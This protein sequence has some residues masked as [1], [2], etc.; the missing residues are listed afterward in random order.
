VIK[1]QHAEHVN[2]ERNGDYV[3]SN[4]HE[5]KKVLIK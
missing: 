3:A 5:V 2:H 4:V 1:I